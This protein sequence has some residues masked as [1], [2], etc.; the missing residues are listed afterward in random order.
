MLHK[1]PAIVGLVRLI[2]IPIFVFGLSPACFSHIPRL[3]LKPIQQ[4]KSPKPP[5]VH[6]GGSHQPTGHGGHLPGDGKCKD[7]QSG[8]LK[9]CKLAI[10]SPF[11]NS[12]CAVPLNLHIKSVSSREEPSCASDVSRE[13]PY[14]FPAC[15]LESKIGPNSPQLN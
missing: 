6:K 4:P 8:Q 2:A 15:S 14:V 11:Q 12:K 13:K 5:E 1:K 10:C 7:K 9:K 3:P